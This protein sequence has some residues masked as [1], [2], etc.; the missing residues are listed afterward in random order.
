[1]KR[2]IPKSNHLKQN[3]F[4]SKFFS[5]WDVLLPPNFELRKCAHALRSH[6][7][8][9]DSYW[10]W[11]PFALGSVPS[12]FS[13]FHTVTV[14]QFYNCIDVGLKWCT[15]SSHNITLDQLARLR[16]ALLQRWWAACK[17]GTSGPNFSHFCI[18][19]L[20]YQDTL[21]LSTYSSGR[22]L[23][24]QPQSYP[25]VVV[26]PA[27]WFWIPFVT[28]VGASRRRNIHNI[29]YGY[30]DFWLIWTCLNLGDE[31]RVPKNWSL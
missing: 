30:K 24:E 28:L 14:F 27:N 2:W 17:V 5:S 25:I 16:E 18:V 10:R 31:F 3:W 9:F 12:S 21:F 6:R 11:K 20:F 26:F 22:N 19:V 1:M 7:A 13:H 29:L 4:C 8:M 23:W 15:S